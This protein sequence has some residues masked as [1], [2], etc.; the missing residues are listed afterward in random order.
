[1]VAVVEQVEGISKELKK[2][3]DK[4]EVE[5]ATH[6]IYDAAI[7]CVHFRQNR[8]SFSKV[9]SQKLKREREK[10]V[11]SL[12]EKTLRVRGAG[13]LANDTSVPDSPISFFSVV[14][15]LHVNLQ[16]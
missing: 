15:S 5:R 11:V 3:R 4:N 14:S 6:S 7:I 13:L 10:K 16:H 12:N 9:P 2:S 8:V 1:M